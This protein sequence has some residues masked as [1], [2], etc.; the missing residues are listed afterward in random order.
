[1]SLKFF[2]RADARGRVLLGFGLFVFV[3]LC[4]VYLS[5]VGAVR[6][7]QN[8]LTF[9]GPPGP[10]KPGDVLVLFRSA[11]DLAD[12]RRA[13][14]VTKE[15]KTILGTVERFGGSNLVNGLRVMRVPADDTLSAIEALSERSDVEFAEPNY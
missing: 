15:R 2:S 9:K 13:A 12:S 1:M 8:K 14:L 5:S 11:S 7:V 3:V 10:Y 4:S 6:T